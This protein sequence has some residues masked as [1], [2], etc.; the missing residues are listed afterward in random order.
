[1]GCTKIAPLRYFGLCSTFVSKAEFSLHQILF[2]KG[3]KSAKTFDIFGTK[4]LSVSSNRKKVPTSKGCDKHMPAIPPIPPATIS[5]AI[6][7]SENKISREFG[8]K[9]YIVTLFP[10]IVK[11]L[12]KNI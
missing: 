8:K 1:M 3:K 11:E 7:L 9:K 4:T 2:Q 10:K 5:T 6:F 12:F